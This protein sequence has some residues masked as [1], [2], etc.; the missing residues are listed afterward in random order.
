LAQFRKSA[1]E[2][3]NIMGSAEEHVLGALLTMKHQPPQ[4]ITTSPQ[5]METEDKAESKF[6]DREDN[7]SS[8]VSAKSGSTAATE[9]EVAQTLIASANERVVK[10]DQD[11]QRDVSPTHHFPYPPPQGEYFSGYPTHQPRHPYGRAPP[12][13]PSYRY[14]VPGAPYF[15]PQP[16]PAQRM[17]PHAPVH[18]PSPCDEKV[19]DEQVE[20]VEFGS[21]ETGDS[22]SNEGSQTT[23]HADA[24]AAPPAK[25]YYQYYHAPP[26][27]PGVY[28]YAA[29]PPFHRLHSYPAY[30]YQPYPAYPARTESPNSRY[31]HPQ[32]YTDAQKTPLGLDGSDAGGADTAEKEHESNAAS[33]TFLRSESMPHV[34]TTHEDP[35]FCNAKHDSKRRASTGRW[36]QEEDQTLRAAV[37][38]NAGKNWKKIALQLPGRTDVQCLHRWQKVLK[39]G[40]VKGPWT[41]EEDAMVV[42]LV[43]E[44]GQKKWSFIARQ[45]QGRLGKQCRERWYN[46][47]SP[48]IKKGGWSEEEDTIIIQMHAK[49]GNKWA[50]ISKSLPGRTDNAIK[51]RWNSTLKRQVKGNDA[52]TARVR[53]RKLSCVNDDPEAKRSAR[54]NIMQEVDDD[55]DVAAAALSGL[56]YIASP[57]GTPIARS[58]SFVT[59]SPKNSIGDL[60]IQATPPK[61]M[62]Q[63]NLTDDGASTRLEPS[64]KIDDRSVF[65]ASLSDASLLMDLN[66][67]TTPSPTRN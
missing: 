21:K 51:N 2:L 5:T 20:K 59:P 43:A 46:H 6:L 1:I 55:V 31:S 42:Q 22:D 25:P 33:R 19:D 10:K 24:K 67:R 14:P 45:L 66:K 63:L 48:D 3:N 23:S 52:S 58:S 39:P 41:P 54:R 18:V 28:P 16:H 12:P 7:T 17:Y 11:V 4:N 62:P 35:Q 37:S 26:P 57:E 30:P 13:P 56:A 29:R 27:P 8:P 15:Y 44:H 34:T 9:E 64:S 36:S 32:P 60:H 40:L 38:S 49:F 50:E 53:K 47:L 61:P 65:Q